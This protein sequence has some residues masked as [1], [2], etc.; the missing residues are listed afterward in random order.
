MLSRLLKY[1]NRDGVRASGAMTSASILGSGRVRAE[2]VTSSVGYTPVAAVATAAGKL[3][4]CC[5]CEV[6]PLRDSW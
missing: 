6:M 1:G 3:H 4:V 2:V 5:C